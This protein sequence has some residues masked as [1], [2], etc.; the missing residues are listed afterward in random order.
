MIQPLGL[1]I[2]YT[3]REYD[4]KEYRLVRMGKNI[5]GAVF[6]TDEGEKVVY[7]D[8]EKK[9]IKEKLDG[10]LRKDKD[11]IFPDYQDAINMGLIVE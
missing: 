4:V 7:F 11:Y 10:V 2:L 8:G 6:S 1:R 5:W 9:D 3:F